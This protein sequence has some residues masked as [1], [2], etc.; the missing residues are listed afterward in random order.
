MTQVEENFRAGNA[1]SVPF[2]K[3]WNLLDIWKNAKE[4][5]SDLYKLDKN[6]EYIEGDKI[7]SWIDKK[8]TGLIGSPPGEEICD[9]FDPFLTKLERLNQ[10]KRKTEVILLRIEEIEAV[11]EEY[12]SEFAF[13]KIYFVG[14]L[15]SFEKE[16]EN[17]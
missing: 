3:I 13:M 17:N 1:I 8:I 9:S 6:D 14:V 11:G 7:L 10:F 12:K 15:E 16:I 2:P 5:Q 4:M